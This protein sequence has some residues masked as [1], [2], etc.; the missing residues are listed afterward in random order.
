MGKSIALDNHV[1]VCY[2]ATILK[3]VNIG[4]GTIIGTQ[5]VITRDVPLRSIA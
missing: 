4:A 2:G 3:G 1:W 5:S